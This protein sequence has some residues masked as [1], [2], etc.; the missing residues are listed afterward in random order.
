MRSI[1]IWA[2]PALLTGLS[3][4]SCAV[5]KGL[6]SA[7]VHNSG[8]P[9]RADRAMM[10]ARQAEFLRDLPQRRIV[11]LPVAVLGRDRRSDTAAA[12]AIARALR[13][14]GIAAATASTADLSLPF[15]PQPNEAAIFWSR[16]KALAVYVAAHPQG[17]PD[18]V[19]LVDV[20]GAPDRGLI[21]AVHV[22]AVTGK[23][24][25]AYRRTWNSQQSLYKEFKPRS[26]GDAGRMVVADLE[27][28][29]ASAK[30]AT[31]LPAQESK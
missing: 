19:M 26:L 12:T 28:R 27:R 17:D 21:P 15:E 5:A 6:Y 13:N 2:F 14:N 30:D 11:I 31:Q 16:F 25:M 23:G 7:V 29:S 4:Q 10:D 3:A 8:A 24:E 9:S 22:M 1:L 18:Y 20:F